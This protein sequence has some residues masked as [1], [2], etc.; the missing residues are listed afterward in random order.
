MGWIR[1]ALARRPRAGTSPSPPR[2]PLP[3]PPPVPDGPAPAAEMQAFRGYEPADLEIFERF[4]PEPAPPEPGFVVDFLNVRTR[5]SSLWEAARH[6]DGQRTGLPV[7]CD[8]HAEAIEWI[9]LLRAAAEARD[10]Y[11]AMEL[12]AGFGPWLVAGAAAARHRGITEIR[13]CG[14][15]ADPDHYA[16]LRRHLADNGLDP[17]AHAL[18][19]AAVGAVAG[20]AR[21]PKASDPVNDWGMRPARD[22]DA[23]DAGYLGGRLD[24]FVDVQILAAADL[25][26][27]EP[28][29][30]LVHV[31]VQGWEAEVLAACG[32]ELDAR[33][34]RLVV[35]THS[36][37]LDGDVLALLHGRGW[38]LE[39][40][41]PTRFTHDPAAP[42]L[43][44]MASMD[45]TQVWRNPRLDR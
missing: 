15:E 40:E 21:W 33:A 16:S 35:G 19:N 3:G 12:G 27:A 29:W 31:D 45:G 22:D 1:D 20:T 25:L 2:A 8:H 36:R 9:G 38:M 4:R 44:S 34:H 23:A 18:H 14:V 39:N 24:R 41:K 37:K 26:R 7:P 17:D 30:D 11:V 10:A 6:L 28:R 5:I 13:L 43:E 42:T 32:P